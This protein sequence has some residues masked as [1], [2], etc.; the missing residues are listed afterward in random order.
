M[1][2]Y[3]GQ[4]DRLR[5]CQ[6]STERPTADPVV[7]RAIPPPDLHALDPPPLPRDLRVWLLA[8]GRSGQVDDVSQQGPQ[9]ASGLSAVH[10][11]PGEEAKLREALDAI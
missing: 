4:R 10:M 5:C 7:D 9:A 8:V 1:T 3:I 11:H 6:N 2:A